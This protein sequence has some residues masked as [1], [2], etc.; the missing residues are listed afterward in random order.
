MKEKR[1]CQYNV[2]LLLTENILY[3]SFFS[4]HLN[5]RFDFSLLRSWRKEKNL[6]MFV[7]ASKSIEHPKIPPL[8]GTSLLA[9]VHSSVLHFANSYRLSYCASQV[10]LLRQ[11][12]VGVGP[13]CHLALCQKS[14][15]TS[16]ESIF[17]TQQQTTHDTLHSKSRPP[18]PMGPPLVLL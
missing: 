10:S 12:N 6:K 17:V 5:I 1:K 13:L 18:I 7:L 3:K 16:I 2:A 11:Q 4:L 9:A 15:S 8:D 14:R